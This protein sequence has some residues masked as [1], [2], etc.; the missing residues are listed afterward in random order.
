MKS[1]NSLSKA[2]MKKVIGGHVDTP[3]CMAGNPCH[4]VT[5][6]DTEDPDPTSW[7][8]LDGTCI[9]EMHGSTVRCGCSSGTLTSNHRE[10]TCWGA[11]PFED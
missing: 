10:G 6:K 8:Y 1:S 4:T 9:M 2:E 3:Y 7:T 11:Q 5:F